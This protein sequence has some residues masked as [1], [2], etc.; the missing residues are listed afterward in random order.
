[1]TRR[2]VFVQ[3]SILWLKS[4]AQAKA[5]LSSQGLWPDW[6]D[7]M[8]KNTDCLMTFSVQKYFSEKKSKVLELSEIF[9]LEVATVIDSLLWSWYKNIIQ[10]ISLS[11]LVKQRSWRGSWESQCTKAQFQLV[12][13]KNDFDWLVDLLGGVWLCVG[14]QNTLGKL[15]FVVWQ[16]VFKSLS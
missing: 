10:N 14:D 3:C 8:A 1:M 15:E 11:W 9:R 12:Y 4:I 7:N 2:A 6:W 16:E 5:R 13:S